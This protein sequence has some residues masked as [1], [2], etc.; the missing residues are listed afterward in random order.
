MDKKQLYNKIMEKVAIQVK[1]ALNEDANEIN[2]STS[3]YDR[4]YSVSFIG[5]KD[6]EGL[7]FSVKI[8]VPY[9]YA[10]EFEKWMAEEEANVIFHACGVRNSDFEI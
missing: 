5:P 9:K 4:V 7:P 1:K 10:D 3:V 8:S 2:E 6:N